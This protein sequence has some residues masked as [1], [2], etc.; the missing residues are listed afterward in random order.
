MST[1]TVLLA[2]VLA[3]AC[4]V[5]CQQ[6]YAQESLK[7]KLDS[8]VD[9]NK[10]NAETKEA[11]AKAKQEALIKE[12]TEKN[13]L[14]IADTPVNE[15]NAL[16]PV[17]NP[18]AG[19]PIQ[20]TAQ[21][22]PEEGMLINEEIDSAAF[23]KRLVNVRKTAITDNLSEEGWQKKFLITEENAYKKQHIL[24]P[25]K[26]VFGWH[27]YWM[28]TAY[29]S[30]NF[31][32]L[33]AVAYFSY[34]LN[35]ASG[36]YTS[37]HDWKTTALI[38]SAHQHNCKV[39][40]S[41]SN[42]GYKNN[43]TF[44][45]NLN[46]QRNFI[47]TLIPL[48]SE[49]NGDGVHIDFEQIPANKRQAFTNF[50]IDLSNS[51]RA[52]RKDYMITLAIPPID[53]ENVYEVK[54]LNNYID[55]YVALGYEFY[56]T[57]SSVAGP[58]APVTS[59]QFWWLYNLERVVDE[60]LISG[61]PPAKFL[62]A[63]PYYGAEWQTNDLKFP[64]PA[65]RFI[66]YPM[67]RS[68]RKTHGSMPCCVDQPSMSKV[69]VYRDNNNNYRQIWYEDSLSLSMKYDWVNG[70]K[71]GGIGIW[72]L[73]YDNGYDELWKVIAAKF[74]AKE[75][76]VAAKNASKL[77]TGAFNRFLNL[78]TRVLTNPKSLL[79]NPRSLV[80]IFGLIFGVSV[81]GVLVL[82][83]Y[84]YRIKRLT[85]LMIKGGVALSVLVLIALV[86]FAFKFTDV[87]EITFLLLGFLI[88]AII[89]YLF[90]RPFLSE[91]DLP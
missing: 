88:G 53:F 91:K 19:N 48:L 81:T 76:P 50:I 5:G 39:L 84:G 64:S 23:K 26:K 13:K 47:N 71:L 38:D 34:E 28:G 40:L 18:E 79:T 14:P 21:Q 31:S 11:E 49:R 32:L 74:T 69:Y 25:A 24:D 20:F 80:S 4:C 10:K 55:L 65:K 3:F 12:A 59:G 70:K 16:T 58:L 35:P 90:S 67:Y 9:T 2:C 61:I 72:A 36:N 45:S 7:G 22:L 82:F 1:Q 27:P 29:K 86:F 46:A 56:G 60:Y 63:V 83:R 51:L 68:I 17:V 43:S 8:Y 77:N 33:S 66:Q 41:V 89:F 57:G 54:Q 75:K 37:I 78:A 30:Y 15:Q 42:T 44:L 52:V 87:N 73:G 6:T 62:L 85:G